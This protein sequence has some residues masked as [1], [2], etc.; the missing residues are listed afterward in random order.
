MIRQMQRP[1]LVGRDREGIHPKHSVKIT[2]IQGAFFPVPPLRGGAVE[3]LW[4]RLA[5]EFADL[6]HE[7]VHIS[8]HWS[9]L[10]EENREN[11]VRHVRVTGYDQPANGLRLK[12]LDLFYSLRAARQVPDSDII[13]TNTFWAPLLLRR[14]RGVYVCVE[15]MPKGQMRLYRRAA[16]LQACSSAVREA[17]LREDSSAEPRVCVV[18]NPLP[19]VPTA[20]VP[21]QAKEERI[22]YVGRVHPEKGIELLLEA[23]VRAKAGALPNWKLE[24]VGP[25][26]TRDGGGGDRWA[27]ILRGRHV[28]PDIE[29]V[30]PLFRPE[31]LA[32]RYRR[33][34][35]FV[36]PS[37]AERGETFGLA[38][39][40]AMAWGAVPIVSALACFRD[41]VTPS[42]NGIVFD[43]RGANSV[44]NL[45]EVFA[46]LP[47]QPLEAMSRG[48]LHVR[49]THA[50]K[51]IAAQFLDDFE[52]IRREKPRKP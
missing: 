8:R 17:I 28:R 20:F 46:G 40:E 38:P 34:R 39:L 21:W 50:P 5:R 26:E 10:P 49:E 13:V 6:G 4:H 36:Y 33:A 42:H 47:Q 1:P 31:E 24:I 2:I 32:A 45:T 25:W 48:A 19:E 11:G 27:Q 44:A 16:R 37:L 7:V 12:L 15:R 51:R 35:V 9:G 52:S 23:F 30:G 43:H 14:R 3:K 18:P 41:F 29:W 22:L